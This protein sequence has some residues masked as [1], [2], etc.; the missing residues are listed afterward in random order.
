MTTL[1]GGRIPLDV[2]ERH[3]ARGCVLGG[4]RRGRGGS[5]GRGGPGATGSS[6]LPPHPTKARPMSARDAARPGPT[7]FRGRVGEPVLLDESPCKRLGAGVFQVVESYHASVQLTAVAVAGEP[8]AEVG[9]R[10]SVGGW[11]TSNAPRSGSVAFA[12]KLRMRRRRLD[13]YQRAPDWPGKQPA[14]QWERSEYDQFLLSRGGDARRRRPRA[15][16]PPAGTG[17]AGRHRGPS[18]PGRPRR[19]AAAGDPAGGCY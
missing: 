1:V 3:A 9:R 18:V 15:R 11:R 14:W 13:A 4:G 5:I 19:L 8:R 10:I 2:G 6:S 7:S 17:V 16:R 12:A